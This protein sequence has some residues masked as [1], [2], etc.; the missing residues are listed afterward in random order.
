MSI[1]EP[2]WSLRMRTKTGE[3]TK[4]SMFFRPPPLL[5]GMFY[6]IV[7]QQDSTNAQIRQSIYAHRNPIN[8]LLVVNVVPTKRVRKRQSPENVFIVDLI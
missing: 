6:S 2:C 3:S 7:G 1:V 8:L 4:C 5:A